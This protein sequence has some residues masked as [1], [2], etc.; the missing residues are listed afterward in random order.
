MC[1][2]NPSEDVNPSQSLKA[3]KPPNSDRFPPAAVQDDIPKAFHKPFSG[4]LQ[5]IYI[6][7][8]HIK[9]KYILRKK[10]LGMC[11][12]LRNGWKTHR[13]IHRTKTNHMRLSHIFVLREFSLPVKEGIELSVIQTCLFCNLRG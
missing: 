7:T 4:G 12:P 9:Y 6:Y 5:Y 11:H 3:P 8:V 10:N 2:V 13:L 1:Q